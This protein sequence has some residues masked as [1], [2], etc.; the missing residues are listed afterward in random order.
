MSDDGLPEPDRVQGAPHPRETLHLYGQSRAEAAF[1]EAFNTGRMHHGWLI[2]GP[3]GIG[4]ATLAWRIARFLLT[5]PDDDAGMFG[6]P[7]APTNL[8]TRPDTPV[9]RRMLQLAESRLFLLRRGQNDKGTALS[10]IISVDE[11]RKLK[12]FFTLT[13][14][15]GGRRVAIIDSADEMNTSSAN[16]LLKLL[17]EPPSG[18][19]FLVISHQP[20]SLLPTIRS[21]C[22]ELRLGPL[23]AP[24]LSDA[25][26]LAGGEVP[27]DAAPALAALAGGSVGEA[28]RLSNLDGLQLYQSIIDLMETLPRMDRQK[29]ISLAESAAGKGRELQFDLTLNL[30]DLFLARLAR[31]GAIGQS[32]PPAAR[33][34]SAT[35]ARL[36][37]GPHHARSWAELAQTLG[38]RARRGRAVNLDPAALL[39]DTLLKID[40][41]AASLQ[42][43]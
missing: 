31:T 41:M 37:P 13:A 10:Q 28:F 19:T 15:D 34:E 18:A 6:A 38:L 17:E 20:Q 22:R 7:P 12:S 4:K 30:I 40:A 23:D 14:A 3:R 32:P 43:G 21:R 36:S 16:A 1:L 9:A 8:D 26:T 29:A 25:L 24:A 11:V 5:L 2:T 27:S 39:L 42:R 33:G 35:L